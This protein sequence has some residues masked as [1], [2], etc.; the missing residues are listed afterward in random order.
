M[1]IYI[2]GASGRNG[3]LVLQEALERGHTVTALVR[4]P[5]SLPPHPNLTVISGTPAS[6][7]DVERG[8]VTPRPAAAVITALGARRTS[9]SP[10]APLRPDDSPPDLLASTT[11][12]LL[13]AI[14]R[15]FSSSESDGGPDSKTASSSMPA[16]PKVVA[17]SSFGA[18][19]SWAAMT[20]PMKLIFSHG[21]MRLSLQGH[22]DMDG[23]VRGSGL[24]FVLARP[25]RLVDG[26]P[27]A[28]RAL[29]DKGHGCGWNPVI[30]RHSAARWLVQAAESDQ[31]D[32]IAP[33]IVN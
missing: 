8:L 4:T 18:G 13:A 12:V 22:N 25:A 1:H 20:W 5:S 32:G 27:S 15:V 23:L 16:P 11:R 19:S 9:D 33:V 14:A 30:T 6:Q 7:A 26:A 29:P 21:A 17:N 24:P 28:V 31:W 10:F 2:A 3:R